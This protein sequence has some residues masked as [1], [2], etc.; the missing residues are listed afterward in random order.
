MGHSFLPKFLPRE[1]VVVD[2]GAN[3]GSFSREVTA[4]Y[5]WRCYAVEPNPEM[6]ELIEPQSVASKENLAIGKTDGPAD[7]HIDLNP[8]SCSLSRLDA[9]PTAK[10]IRVEAVTL[11]TLQQRLNLQRVDLLKI[12]IEGSEIEVLNTSPAE[13]LRGIRQITVEFH[14]SSGRNKV[15]EVRATIRRLES[16]GFVSVKMSMSH[17]GDVLF[18]N[19]S[20]CH[21]TRWDRVKLRFFLRSQIWAARA[22]QHLT[23]RLPESNGK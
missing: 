20:R 11:A 6:F 1:S 10:S 18:I 22:W 17:Y 2:L 15:V 9:D 23:R 14:E 12:D 8:E 4:A 16:L 5:G 7:F 3:R 13:L 19:A 21:F